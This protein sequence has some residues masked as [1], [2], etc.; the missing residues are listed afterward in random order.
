VVIFGILAPLDQSAVLH[1]I[2][3]DNQLAGGHSQSRSE[4]LLSR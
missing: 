3:D 4:R 1:F 2:H